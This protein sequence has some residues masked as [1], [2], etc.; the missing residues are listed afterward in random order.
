MKR[1]LKWLKVLAL[2][3]VA[4]L[5]LAAVWGA[6]F[7]RRPWPE[8]AG[9]ALVDGLDAPVEVTRDRW[10]V[11]HLYARNEADL[12]F[13][14]GYVHAQDRF[15]QMHFSRT[16]AHGRL[17]AALGA[18]ALDTDRLIRTLGFTRAAERDWE[19]L[20]PEARGLLEAYCR[21]VNAY[22]EGHRGRLPLEFTILGIEPEPWTPLDSLA[23]TK[24]MSYQLSLN[25]SRETLRHR[26]FAQLGDLGPDAARWLLPPYPE[27]APVIVGSGGGGAAAAETGGLALLDAALGQ[28]G[29]GRGSNSWVVHGSRTATG[30]P[31]LANDTHLG[32]GMPSVWYENGLHGGRFDVV[33]FSFPGLPAVLIGHNGRIAWGITSMASDIQ[34]L[35]LEELEP[36]DPPRRYRFQD[37]WRDLARVAEVIEVKGGEPQTLEVLLSHHGPLVNALYDSIRDAQPMALA[38]T[39]LDGSPLIRALLDLDLAGSWD[40]FRAA[41]AGW[42]APSLSFVYADVLGNIGFQGTGRLPLRAPGHDGTVPVPGWSGEHDWQGWIPYAE[43]PMAFNPAA[44]FLVTANNQVVADDYPHLITRDWAESRRAR[45]ITEVLAADP[46]VSLDAVRRLQADTHDLLAQDLVPYLLAARPAGDL[47]FRALAAV[48]QW[49]LAYQPDRVGA[50]VFQAWHGFLLRNLVADELGEELMERY[51]TIPL[52]QTSVTAELMARD[53]SPWF[54]DRATPEVET[55]EVIV[56]RS[57]SQAVA[58]LAQRLG[59]DVAA[60]RWG[61]LHTVSFVHAPLGQSGIGPLMKIFNTDPLPAPGGPFTVNAATPALSRPYAVVSGASQRFIADLGDLARSLAVNTTGQSGHA[62]HRHRADQVELWLEVGYRPVLH[63][64]ETV[65][66]AA[67]GTLLLRPR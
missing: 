48:E 14:Q 62:F 19:V 21:G 31:L 42:H 13:A 16:L 29:L 32:L 36:A 58:W 49:D 43:M 66:A 39:A 40:E 28:P 64:R 30:A 59:D 27:G 35:Y 10:G 9:E 56:Q 22:L 15:W 51:A 60:W 5:L 1:F 8:V 50:T 25:L 20:D 44:G 7:V 26:F 17:A 37:G 47:E 3:L 6:W 18:L 41:L 11:P 57:L 52:Q 46:G 23:F 38:W 4:L 54:D 24:L 63:A 45:R 61:R 65:A 67:E 33:G 34:D 55:R 2:A 12:F 53:G